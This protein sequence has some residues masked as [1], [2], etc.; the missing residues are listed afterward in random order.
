MRMLIEADFLM[1]RA[2]GRSIISL[3]GSEK[4]NPILN[5]H[6][7]R[8]NGTNQEKFRGVCRIKQGCANLSILSMG[9][10]AGLREAMVAEVLPSVFSAETARYSNPKFASTDGLVRI[11]PDSLV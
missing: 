11:Y 5:D 8:L 2:A 7:K 10:C 6:Y 9:V 1:F 4:I 3:P